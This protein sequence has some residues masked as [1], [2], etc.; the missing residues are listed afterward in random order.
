MTTLKSGASSISVSK[1]QLS[2]GKEPVTKFLRDLVEY[3]ELPDSS[4]STVGGTYK[5]NDKKKTTE[6]TIKLDVS[7]IP[8]ALRLSLIQ[9]LIGKE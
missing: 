8:P 3:I 7:S 2:S 9:F 6:I 4:V 1:R 5:D